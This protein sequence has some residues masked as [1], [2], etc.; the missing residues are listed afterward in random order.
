[1]AI[2]VTD[3][4]SAQ[5][6][7]GATLTLTGVT[8]PAGALI[9]V[10]VCEQ[11]NTINGI[12]ISDGTGNFYNVAVGA[13]NGG[14]IAN[15]YGVAYYCVNAVALSGATITYTKGVSGSRTAMSAFYA[16]GVNK[17]SP[18]DSSLNASASGTSTSPSVTSGTPKQGGELIVGLL[19]WQS[20]SGDTFTQ[21]ST[22]AAYAAPPDAQGTAPAGAAVAGGFVIG[23]SPGVAITYAPTINNSRPW[24]AQIIGF[25]PDPPP[26]GW[27]ESGRNESGDNLVRAMNTAL[28]VPY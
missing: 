7:S 15:G 2:A 17:S 28:P 25:L 6:G 3:L 12:A 19:A 14:S 26:P 13:A 4:G 18:F 5:N 11:S 22:H 27:L 24:S 16:T 8:V 20:V 23:P 9:F 21:D 1:M 10:Q